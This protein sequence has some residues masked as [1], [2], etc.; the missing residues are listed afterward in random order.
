MFVKNVPQI[1]TYTNKG[2][3]KPDNETTEVDENGVLS[4]VKPPQ[5]V[6]WT[7]GSDDEIE[8]MIN[9]Y[10]DGKLSLEDVKSAWSVGDV[11]QANE[12]DKAKF[13]VA[14]NVA[15]RVYNGSGSGQSTN[16][17]MVEMKTVKQVI[18][19]FNHSILK[20]AIN[21]ISNALITIQMTAL[22]SNSTNG[23]QQGTMS[24]NDDRTNTGGQ[25]GSVLYNYLNGNFYDAC[26]FK[27][28]VK[29]VKNP[30][31]L[32]SN[33]DT[34]TQCEDKIFLLSEIEVFNT[35]FQSR[36]GEGTQYKYFETSSNRIKNYGQEG[37]GSLA[38]QQ[39]RSVVNNNSTQFCL[40]SGEDEVGRMQAADSGVGVSPAC[41][42]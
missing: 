41:A 39:E 12:T 4:L 25:S 36:G 26:G 15:P 35:T 19:D 6:A 31:K 9:G 14:S 1:A 17:T 42:L 40:V 23:S 10:Y 22:I 3:L 37:A 11:R 7:S 29:V 18:I 28:L 27:N 32:N 20:T 24:M 33:S 16:V 5:V 21:S 30:T 8:A 38:S 34:L 2:I 13:K